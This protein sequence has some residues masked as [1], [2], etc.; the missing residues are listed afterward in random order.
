VYFI[1]V[2]ALL[3]KFKETAAPLLRI[4]PVNDFE[5]YFLAQHYGIPT[6]LLD[7][8]TDPLVALFFSMPTNDNIIIHASIDDAIS[9][10]SPF[11]GITI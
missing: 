5:W 11:T 10:S 8:S 2:E 9:G 4:Q 3:E 1:E 7:W 6:T